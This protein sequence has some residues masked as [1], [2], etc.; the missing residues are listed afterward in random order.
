MLL[1]LHFSQHVGRSD[2]EKNRKGRVSD[3]PERLYDTHVHICMYVLNDNK[4][5]PGR[6]RS[7]YSADEDSAELELI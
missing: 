5:P 6:G 1:F 7:T 3:G 4:E 2:A